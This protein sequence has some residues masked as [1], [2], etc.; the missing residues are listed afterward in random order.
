[1]LGE[2][3]TNL[4]FPVSDSTSVTGKPIFDWCLGSS[5][6]P[7]SYIVRVGV[8]SS[9]IQTIW[10]AEVASRK[11]DGCQGSDPQDHLTFH[12]FS[13]VPNTPAAGDSLMALTTVTVIRD[14]DTNYMNGGR[15]KKG[16]YFW[17]VDCDYGIN[18]KSKSGWEPFLVNRD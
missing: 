5:Q 10:I 11:F 7:G 1:M 6:P 2:K 15:L 16:P 14:F 9:S 3:V 4:I 8:G 17:R 13:Y 12:N 18:H